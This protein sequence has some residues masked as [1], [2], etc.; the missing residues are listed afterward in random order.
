[1]KNRRINKK[2]LFA[3]MIG[4]QLVG[5]GLLFWDMWQSTWGF[6]N[7]LERNKPGQGNYTEEMEIEGE[8]YSGNYTV[9]VEERHF[10][11]EEAEKLFRRAKREIDREFLG[12]NKDTEHVMY[13]VVIRKK[14]QRGK[15]KAEWNFDDGTRINTEGKIQMEEV[16]KPVIIQA[17]VQLKCQDR[18]SIYSFPF[19]VIPVPK[20]SKEG[21]LLAVKKQIQKNSTDNQKLKLPTKINGQV[22]KWKKKKSFRGVWLMVLGLSLPVIVFYGQKVEKK[23]DDERRKNILQQDYPLI[24]GQMSLLLG[25]GISF[26]EAV[27]KI[28]T[29]YER[30]RRHGEK[31]REGYELLTQMNREMRDGVSEVMALEH[32]GRRAEIKEYRKLALLLEQ[33]QRKGNAQVREQLENEN[34]NA[35]EMRKLTAKKL[36]EEASTKLLFPMMG[37]LAMVLVIIVIP[38]LMKVK[39][40]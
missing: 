26:S 16:K 22:V 13:D 6:Q 37:M 30:G 10:S 29:R 18:E 40:T 39:I 5:L 35:F 17:S 33:Y 14:Y 24:V 9:E 2:Q 1:M 4:M 15:V 20:N 21:F 19:R 31:S 25:V 8:S 38:A 23:R 11:E 36:G 7:R 27:S 12:R 28:C 32:F 3:I 34:I